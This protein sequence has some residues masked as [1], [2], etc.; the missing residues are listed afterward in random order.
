[1]RAMARAKGS[2]PPPPRAGAFMTSLPS[3]APTE[4][5]AWTTRSAACDRHD[6]ADRRLALSARSGQDMRDAP[7]SYHLDRR[8]LLDSAHLRPLASGP[9]PLAS[10]PVPPVPP[11]PPP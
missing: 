10:S 8:P 1:M 9:S 6:G 5:A 3:T 4:N 2:T 7:G 11:E